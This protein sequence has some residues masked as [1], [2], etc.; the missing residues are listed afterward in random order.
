MALESRFQSK[1]I[2]EIKGKFP[3]AIVLKND[4]KYLQGFPDLVV[5][6]LGKFFVL[7]CKKSKNA[8]HRPN[9]GYY[10]RKLGEMVHAAF[11]YPENKE[12]VLHAMEKTFRARG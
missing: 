9:Q 6:Y 2:K 8:H 10:I 3:G 4:P 1:L 7:E 5:L 12:E 11:V